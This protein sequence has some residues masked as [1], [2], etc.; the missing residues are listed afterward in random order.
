MTQ[1]LVRRN[2]VFRQ[3]L[4]FDPGSLYDTYD[5]TRKADLGKHWSMFNLY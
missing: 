5:P 2:N 1:K 3:F 4:N